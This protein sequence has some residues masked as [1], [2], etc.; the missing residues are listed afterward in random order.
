MAT[1]AEM[2]TTVDWETYEVRVRWTNGRGE[3]DE[4]ITNRHRATILVCRIR[5]FHGFDHPM[6]IHQRLMRYNKAWEPVHLDDLKRKIG[7][8]HRERLKRLPGWNRNA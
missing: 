3:V 2:E 4:V 7:R 1:A 6:E 5:A 8:A